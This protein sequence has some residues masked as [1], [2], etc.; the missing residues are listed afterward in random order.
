MTVPKLWL[1]IIS[2]VTHNTLKCRA[3]HMTIFTSKGPKLLQLNG[4]DEWGGQF[5]FPYLPLK[6]APFNLVNNFFVLLL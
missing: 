4:G 1:K 6:G 5:P 2:M 3:L